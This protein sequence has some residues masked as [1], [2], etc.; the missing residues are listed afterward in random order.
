[1]AENTDKA[2][3]TIDEDAKR[4]QKLFEGEALGSRGVRQ[5]VVCAGYAIAAAIV[6]AARLHRPRPTKPCH[7][8]PF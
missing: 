6:C 2:E 8:G 7:R 3:L 1:M 5:P 4:L